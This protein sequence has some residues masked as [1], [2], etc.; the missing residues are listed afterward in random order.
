M[1]VAS[2]CHFAASSSVFTSSLLA[3]WPKFFSGKMSST[4]PL[5]A[6][7]TMIPPIMEPTP[8]KV[9]QNLTIYYPKEHCK[10]FEILKVLANITLAKLNAR[11]ACRAHVVCGCTPEA[12][13]AAR[14]TLK[15]KSSTVFL[16]AIAVF[17]TEEKGLKKVS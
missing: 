11:Q 1:A 17:Q 6:C 4:P 13:C 14:T 10:E 2:R 3:N 7:M 12:A 9:S 5:P 16:A 15:L 8:C